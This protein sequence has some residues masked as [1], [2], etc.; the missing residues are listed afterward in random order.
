MSKKPTA[1]PEAPKE[2]TL[3]DVMGALTALA[4]RIESL[5]QGT[6]AKQEAQEAEQRSA[7]E[8]AA[9]ATRDPVTIR[10]FAEARGAKEEWKQEQTDEYAH[11]LMRV[12]MN[13]NAHDPFND[14]QTAALGKVRTT[15]E[16]TVMVSEKPYKVK[17]ELY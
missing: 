14:R 13:Q 5:E 15:K 8:M 17:V 7:E 10:A 1:K 3:A 11:E 9:I 2:P 12:A 6:V 4:G 16:H